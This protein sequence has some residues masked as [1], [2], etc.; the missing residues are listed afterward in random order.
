MEKLENLLTKKFDELPTITKR[1][2]AIM[3]FI[4]FFGY[5]V[6]VEIKLNWQMNN[7]STFTLLLIF[8]VTWLIGYTLYAQFPSLSCVELLGGSALLLSSAAK[9]VTFVL[10]PAKFAQLMK[11]IENVCDINQS[12]YREIILRNTTATVVR[13]CKFVFGGIVSGLALYSCWPCYDFFI[14]G[15]YTLVSP[16]R[17][18]FVDETTFKGYLILTFVNIFAASV[19]V[20]GTYTYS[21][22]FLSYV[23]VY[24]GL[25]SLVV[26]DFGLFD[27]MHDKRSQFRPECACIF[28]NTMVELMDMARFNFAM[29]ELFDDCA[30][31][32]IVCC[33]Y[34]IVVVLFGYL[35]NDYIGGIGAAAYFITELLMF[36]FIGQLLQN[37]NDRILMVLYDT[38]WY[39]YD[40]AYQKDILFALLIFQD[41]QPISV[42]SLYPLN[43]ETGLQVVNNIYSSL[44]IILEFLDK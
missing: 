31:V 5:F 41:L 23:D 3:D 18:P 2:S 42:A 10:N 24:D 35:A 20:F 1:M 9:Y 21:C 14:N 26:D 25:L 16:L 40:V 33:F 22:I 29:R 30:T 44:M 15:N 39:T 4:N 8:I 19:A 6:G 12:G 17:M 34:G 36:C 43:F 28:R 7:R 37:T 32:E 38:K 27:R 11:F 13:H